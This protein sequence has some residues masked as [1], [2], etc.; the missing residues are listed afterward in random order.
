MLDESSLMGLVAYFIEYIEESKEWGHIPLYRNF[1]KYLRLYYTQYSM[2]DLFRNGP[3]KALLFDLLSYGLKLNNRNEYCL[4]TLAKFVSYEGN[5]WKL[6]Q[7]YL[8]K[9]HWNEIIACYY[10]DYNSSLLKMYDNL[11]WY[12]QNP[13]E[14]KAKKFQAHQVFKPTLEYMSKHCEATVGNCR[15]ICT[16]VFDKEINRRL[17]DQK[18]GREIYGLRLQKFLHLLCSEFLLRA[19]GLQLDKNEEKEE[20]KS[21]DNKGEDL[22]T[23]MWDYLNHEIFVFYFLPDWIRADPVH[24]NEMQVEK[25]KNSIW[26]I[27]YDYARYKKFTDAS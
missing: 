23:I 1:P 21:S 14:E 9:S 5:Y 26:L 27:H 7:H 6:S 19:V 15:K 2:H 20:N 18:I 4:L 8:N 11:K 16:E 24:S 12:E 10:W 17:E 22:E 3:K 25:P 13:F